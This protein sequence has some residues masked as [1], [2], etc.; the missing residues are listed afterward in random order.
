MGTRVT[1]RWIAICSGGPTPRQAGSAALCHPLGDQ[2]QGPRPPAPPTRDFC[3][4]GLGPTSLSAQPS[5]PVSANLI[6]LQ[7]VW[8]EG[9]ENAPTSSLPRPPPKS[10]ALSVTTASCLGP[11][12]ARQPAQPPSDS[13]RCFTSHQS[14]SSG[15]D[16]CGPAAF[17]APHELWGQPTA[18]R[19]RERPPLTPRA[20]PRPLRPLRH[21]ARWVRLSG[22]H[23][24]TRQ[25]P[26]A[27]A[28]LYAFR[29]GLAPF[30]EETGFHLK[31]ALKENTLLLAF[32]SVYEEQKRGRC[33]LEGARWR[34]A[35]TPHGPCASC[36][37]AGGAS[38]A[39]RAGSPPRGARSR[40]PQPTSLPP[41]TP[42]ATEVWA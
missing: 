41:T 34:W 40:R 18:T 27:G 4:P 5:M 14:T 17:S 13:N 9:D 39:G 31:V 6:R 22:W 19:T 21:S 26:A 33:L 25:G 11:P 24:A 23:P 1:G 8:V 36:S 10:R 29:A 3:V 16:T 38:G 32:Y 28:A 37:G 2:A 15:V 30:S 42:R 12:A 7:T 20:R 35:P